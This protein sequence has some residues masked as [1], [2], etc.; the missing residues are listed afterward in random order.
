MWMTASSCS[1]MSE[2]MSEFIEYKV[3]NTFARDLTIL[4][5]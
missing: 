4:N 2:F 3:Y 5:C 1:I